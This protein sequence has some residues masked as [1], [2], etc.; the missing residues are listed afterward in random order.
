[1]DSFPFFR[2]PPEVRTMIYGLLFET[3]Y[4]DKTVTP[5][6]AGSRRE[7][8]LGA[9][10][11]NLGDSLPF[12]RICKLVHQ[13]ATAVLYGSNVFRFDDHPHNSDQHKILGFNMSVPCCDYLTMY[14]FLVSIGK[15][16]REKLQ[17]IHLDFSTPTF[18]RYPEEV[19]EYQ[20]LCSE[21]AGASLIGDAVELLAASH[22]LQTVS[23]SF[24]AGPHSKVYIP[25]HAFAMMAFFVLFPKLAGKISAIT[26]IGQFLTFLNAS[27]KESVT[28]EEAAGQV[29]KIKIQE[30][31][32]KM[33]VVY[34]RY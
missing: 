26:G 4:E 21:G 29:V 9:R 18:G 34:P 11:M 23:V 5:D 20:A 6:P 17:H 28:M 25:M 31:K 24:T 16:N 32:A 3:A 10:T 14:F 1:M 27:G 19:F 8:N 30:M 2:L 7:N 33:E 15:S 12:L 13:E 22:N